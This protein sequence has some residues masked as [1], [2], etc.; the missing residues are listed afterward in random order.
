MLNAEVNSLQ[1]YERGKTGGESSYTKAGREA[2]TNYLLILNTMNPIKMIVKDLM[3]SAGFKCKNN[4]WYRLR[5][6]L[7]QILNIQKSAWG[8]Q[9][10]INLGLDYYDGSFAYPSEYKFLGECMFGLRIRASSL[11]EDADFKSLDFTK[12][13]DA[14]KRTEAIIIIFK[15]SLDFLDKCNS[16]SV[17]KEDYKDLCLYYLSVSPLRDVILRHSGTL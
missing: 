17:L 12:D 4:S 7:I 10:Y 11:F 16:T 1:E 14:D 13:Y 9:Y 3:K 8:D 6:D 2:H 15:R 5:N